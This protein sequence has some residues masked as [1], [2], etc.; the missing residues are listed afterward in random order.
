MFSCVSFFCV[1]SK[2]GGIKRAEIGI[3]GGDL[4]GVDDLL[5]TYGIK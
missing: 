1:G 3:F 2:R 5:M 4:D